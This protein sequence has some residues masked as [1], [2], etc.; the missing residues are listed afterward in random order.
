MT[1]TAYDARL[2]ILDAINSRLEA[3]PTAADVAA[4]TVYSEG[5]VPAEP[6]KIVTPS[7]PDKTGRIAPYAVVYPSPGSRPNPDFEGG[8]TLGAGDFLW[9]GQ[10]TLVAGY[11][12]TLVDVLDRVIPWLESWMPEIDGLA[13][14]WFEQNPNTTPATIRRNAQVSPSRYSVPTLWQL[15][16][17][18]A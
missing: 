5:E 13:C 12:R 4:L 9:S 3:L 16:V 2:A 10:L 17:A 11:R 15:H 18:T 8:L 6:P 7:G 14:G 1:V